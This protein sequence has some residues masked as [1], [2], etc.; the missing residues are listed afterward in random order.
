MS[1]ISNISFYYIHLFYISMLL[2]HY[3]SASLRYMT[4]LFWYL[5]ILYTSFRDI[6]TKV[7]AISNLF[8]FC[9]WDYPFFPNF[10]FFLGILSSIIDTIVELLIS[11]SNSIWTKSRCAISIVLIMFI[12]DIIFWII[13]Q[14]F[15]SCHDS[16]YMFFHT[17][18][19][20]ILQHVV[21]RL[22]I[23]SSSSSS[24]SSLCSV[25]CS[26]YL[27]YSRSTSVQA[28]LNSLQLFSSIFKIMLSSIDYLL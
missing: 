17:S 24:S 10:F 16:V 28:C 4:P 20:L 15:N 14:V 12:G 18:F 1:D 5:E 8:F 22:L 19:Y 7:V 3:S 11:F 25:T 23:N 27:S 6:P 9:Y 13:W 2:I 21:C 26:T